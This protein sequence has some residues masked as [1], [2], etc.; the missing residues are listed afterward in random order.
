MI[1]QPQPYHTKKVGNQL[2]PRTLARQPV[3]YFLLHLNNNL[4]TPNVKWHDV[5]FA[6]LLSSKADHISSSD[7][8]IK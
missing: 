4:T 3:P 2:P 6:D 1:H 8:S 5:Q 7:P